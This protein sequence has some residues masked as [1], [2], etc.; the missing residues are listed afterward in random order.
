MWA[1]ASQDWSRSSWTIQ[2]GVCELHFLAECNNTFV[3]SKR[4]TR[5][6][7]GLTHIRSCGRPYN[8]PPVHRGVDHLLVVAGTLCL[9]GFVPAT[10]RRCFR[11]DPEPNASA[12]L[13]SALVCLGEL[14]QPPDRSPVTCGRS[15]DA[16]CFRG[17]HHRGD[18]N[19][20][21]DED[22]GSN[23]SRPLSAEA[24]VGRWVPTPVGRCVL[25][26]FGEI[27]QARIVVRWLVARQRR[28][29][30]LRSLT[31]TLGAQPSYPSAIGVI[32]NAVT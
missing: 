11:W 8:P 24:F 20:G 30:A 6:E 3:L 27:R 31:A 15:N 28:L 26:R 21:R 29:Y 13:R 16:P 10:L 19:S 7:R 22:G 12:D 2:A 1:S 14:R 4:K 23:S 18:A 17:T 5:Q 25:V 9:G 32:C